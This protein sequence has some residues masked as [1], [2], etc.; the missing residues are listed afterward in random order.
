MGFSRQE[1]WS[2]V[3][4]P[5]L[6]QQQQDSYTVGIILFIL[7]RKTG[8]LW[9]KSQKAG[10]DQAEIQ[11]KFSEALKPQDTFNYLMLKL[12][13]FSYF[14]DNFPKWKFKYTNKIA[15]QS[16]NTFSPFTS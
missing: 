12:S 1:Y 16:Q 13:R 14:M 4:S 2:G 7:H 11:A 10:G 15:S 3:P 8:V 5:S 9:P 6:K